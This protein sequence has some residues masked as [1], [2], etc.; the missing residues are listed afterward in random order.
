ME[1]LPIRTEID[2][3]QALQEIE[4]LF[5]AAPNTPEFDRLDVL[6]TLVE[7]YE[8]RHFPIELPFAE[9]QREIQIG[10]DASARGEIIQGEVMF[11]QL[12]EKLQ[13]RRSDLT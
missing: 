1:L 8:K 13:Q 5:D 11:D 7:S 12:R 6:S 3:Q 2:Y 4:L 10:L 9:L